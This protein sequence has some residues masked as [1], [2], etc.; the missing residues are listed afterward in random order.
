MSRGKIKAS[1]AIATLPLILSAMTLVAFGY[2]S[3]FYSQ[4]SPLIRTNNLTDSVSSSLSVSES[5]SEPESILD[6][7]IVYPPLQSNPAAAEEYPVYRSLLNI[8]SDWNPDNPEPPM[9]QFRETLQHFN[10]SDPNELI[11][12]TKFRDAELPFKVFNVPEINSISEKWSDEYL[13]EQFKGRIQSHHVEKSKN[14][15]FMFWNPMLR[16]QI[17]GYKPP[18]EFVDGMPFDT[19]LRM[20]THADNV[21]VK[22]ESIHYYF[23]ANANA[24][25]Q[26]TSFIGRDL[27]LFSTRKNNFFVSNVAANKGIQCRFGMRGTIAEAHYDQG[28]N[29]VAML[30]GAKRY[31]LNPPKEYKKLGLIT[32][33]KHPSYR[34]S[35]ID[36]SVISQATSRGFASVDA[37]D[38]IVQRGEVLYI[39]SYWFH[40]I[41]SL[42]YSI[43]CNSRSGSPPNRDGQEYI[44]DCLGEKLALRR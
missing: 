10:Y 33:S 19:W 12:A 24:G 16:G 17:K 14:N 7:K 32:D 27:K 1:F 44:E 39:P 18:T 5:H 11:M 41:I 29:M 30:G 15:H 43:Q 21:K 31:I 6:V 34:H 35:V 13:G 26:R 36:W 9:T 40:Y 2:F 4:L 37:I 3:V 8:I 42:K 25:D 38:T 22:N 20:A 28:R 23:M